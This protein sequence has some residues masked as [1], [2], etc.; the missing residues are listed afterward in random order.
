MLQTARSQLRSPS[1][2]DTTFLLLHVITA[3]IEVGIIVRKSES[4]ARAPGELR[5][6]HVERFRDES[7]L[8]RVHVRVFGGTQSGNGSG[9]RRPGSGNR[10]FRSGTFGS[11]YGIGV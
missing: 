6:S 11:S 3:C 5:A 4:A 9:P 1:G 2:S 8:F 7:E 10:V